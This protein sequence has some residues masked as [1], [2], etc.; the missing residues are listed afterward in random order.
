MATP[1]A[2]VAAFEP[3]YF[4]MMMMMI[5]DL[6]R[7]MMVKVVVVL[8]VVV[9][10]VGNHKHRQQVHTVI[11]LAKQTP[12]QVYPYTDSCVVRVHAPE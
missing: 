1:V 9:T 4:A 12:P 5:V 2:A 11:F 10:V 6:S 3:F 7:F 8:V